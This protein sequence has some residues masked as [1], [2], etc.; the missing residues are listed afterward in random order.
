MEKKKDLSW[1]ER[2][3]NGDLSY[4][5]FLDSFEDV[6]T[7]NGVGAKVALRTLKYYLEEEIGY[8]LSDKAFLAIFFKVINLRPARP[9]G[10]W[11]FHYGYVVPMA[12]LLQKYKIDCGLH[13]IFKF[14]RVRNEDNRHYSNIILHIPHSSIAFP[15]GNMNFKDLDEE[16]RLLIDYYTDE[17]FVPEQETSNICHMIFPYCRLFC[18]VERLIHDPLEKK[19][20]GISYS[21]W[22]P[23]KDG[24]GKVLRSYSGGIEA[25][26]LYSDFHSEVSK[27]IAGLLGSILLIDC[28][29]FSALPNLLNSNP[30]DIDICIGYNDDETCPNKVIVG[31]IVQYFKSKGYK[32]GI[33]EPFSNSKTFSVPVPYH[34]VMIEIN[35]RVYMDEHTLE[36][37]EGFE[38]LKHDI[39][40]L[41]MIL[42]KDIS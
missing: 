25:F 22:V 13:P 29:S 34:S 19:G 7:L 16:E 10:G 27:K 8:E 5:T 24:Y 37:T 30:P 41:Y 23:C 26:A 11:S 39:H 18:D 42:L 31:N 2:H 21:R 9:L 38:R 17:L 6:S 32:V 4:H 3:P 33:N 28:H 12:K 36:K 15:N 14:F 40:S 35:K 20:M 1:D